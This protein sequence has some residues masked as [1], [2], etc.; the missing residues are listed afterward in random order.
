MFE[1]K[2]IGE[3]QCDVCVKDTNVFEVKYDDG[4]RAKLCEPDMI[5]R[6]KRLHEKAKPQSKSDGKAQPEQK[7]ARKEG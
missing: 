5:K 3:G 6:E 7:Q 1:A 2:F 4:Y